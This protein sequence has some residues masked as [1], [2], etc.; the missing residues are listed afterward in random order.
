MQEFKTA[1]DSL[2]ISET[3]ISPDWTLLETN[4]LM[5][6]TEINEN[7]KELKCPRHINILDM[8]EIIKLFCQLGC[9]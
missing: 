7:D 1:G 2:T 8:Q 9:I 3:L 6:C 5:G 4:G